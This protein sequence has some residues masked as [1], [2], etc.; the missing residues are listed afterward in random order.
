MSI[1]NLILFYYQVTCWQGTIDDPSDRRNTL[2]TSSSSIPSAVPCTQ[3]IPTDD[4]MTVNTV[5]GRDLSWRGNVVALTEA[6]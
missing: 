1:S 3:Q 5:T 6:R 4:P 2:L